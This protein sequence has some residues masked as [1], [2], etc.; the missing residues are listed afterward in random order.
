MPG[1]S[2]SFPD[3]LR[4]S[5]SKASDEPGL[6]GLAI[7]PWALPREREAVKWNLGANLV[8]L[9]PGEIE[10]GAAALDLGGEEDPFPVAESPLK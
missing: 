4:E 5:S 10:V 6:H 9:R 1:L 8:S 2:E 7:L 3:P